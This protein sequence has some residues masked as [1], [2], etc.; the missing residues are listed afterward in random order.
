MV[1]SRGWSPPAGVIFASRAVGRVVQE[2]AD[3]RGGRVGRCEEI[4]VVLLRS[5]LLGDVA[6]AGAADAV[7]PGDVAA[8]AAMLCGEV[9]AAAAAVLPDEVAAAA[10]VLTVEVAAAVLPGEEVAAA[11]AAV[12]RCDAAATAVVAFADS[13]SVLLGGG[14]CSR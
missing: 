5:V 13:S 10:A 14:G 2:L 11:A 6:A 7:L 1:V 8:A 4:A 3:R 9:V 12:L